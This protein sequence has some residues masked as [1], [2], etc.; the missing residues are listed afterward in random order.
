VRPGD[1][2]ATGVVGGQQIELADL[3]A[4]GFEFAFEASDVVDGVVG[5]DGLVEFD[6]G[7]LFGCV[8][9]GADDFV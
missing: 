5:G 1:H 7:A 4:Q 6:E 9:A 8:D 3:L 2:L